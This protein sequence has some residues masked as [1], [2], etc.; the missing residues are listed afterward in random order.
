MIRLWLQAM[1][2]P[3]C[4]CPLPGIAHEWRLLLV[5]ERCI[6][7]V[8]WCPQRAHVHARDCR[9]Q[10]DTLGGAN[11]W[12]GTDGVSR[13]RFANQ[14]LQPSRSRRFSEAIVERMSESN[15]V[16]KIFSDVCLCVC[17]YR[18]VERCY[19]QSAVMPRQVA[20]PCV[21]CDHIHCNTVK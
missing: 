19:T 20:C 3:D 12:R 7:G 4:R 15:I 14:S 13:R 1:L 18:A 11:L 2:V 6:N 9:N 17:F 8:E 5:S 21:R 10:S 16:S